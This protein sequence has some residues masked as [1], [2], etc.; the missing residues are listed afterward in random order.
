MIYLRKKIKQI[1]LKEEFGIE[2]DVTGQDYI[3]YNIK[4]EEIEPFLD[5]LKNIVGEDR[6]QELYENKVKRDGE[7]FH[8]TILNSKEYKKLKKYGINPEEINFPDI[9]EPEFK[10]IGKAEK[11]DNIAYFVVVNINGINKVLE[12]LNERLKEEKRKRGKKIKDESEISKKDLHVTLGFSD[13]DVHSVDKSIN[14]L[15]S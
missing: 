6:F 11:N 4:K 3:I 8:I 12:Q 13:K 10:G 5:K 2:K 14:S 9:S 1:I 7:N 15:I